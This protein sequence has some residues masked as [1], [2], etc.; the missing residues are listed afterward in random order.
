MR[1]RVRTRERGHELGLSLGRVHGLGLGSGPGVSNILGLGNCLVPGFG[2]ILGLGH[3]LCLDLDLCLVLVLGFWLCLG[4]FLCH[5]LGP[6][7]GLAHGLGH[8]PG[9]VARLCLGIALHPLAPSTLSGI[10][11]LNRSRQKTAQKRLRIFKK[12]KAGTVLTPLLVMVL[13]S[14]LPFI[15]WHLSCCPPTH[16]PIDL[17]LEKVCNCDPEK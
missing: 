7:L 3:F 13:L 11:S 14:L 5:V 4:H 6:C 9:H 2:L 1:T 16:H 17:D 8:G 10:P 12:W 15:S